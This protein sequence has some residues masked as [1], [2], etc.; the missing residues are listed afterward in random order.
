MAK[1]IKEDQEAIHPASKDGGR[2]LNSRNTE[3]E[4]M[5]EI[6]SL[7]DQATQ[8]S[9]DL[10]QQRLDQLPDSY[11]GLFDA[12]AVQELVG[13]RQ[14]EE[15][16]SHMGMT[17]PA[18]NNTQQTVLAIQRG[19]SDYRLRQ[20]QQQRAR[21]LEDQISLVQAV[22]EAQM[23]QQTA[24]LRRDAANRDTDLLADAYFQSA[25]QAVAQYIDDQYTA[26]LE[27]QEAL[28][29]AFNAQQ[30]EKIQQARNS[31]T[32]LQAIGQDTAYDPL[33]NTDPARRGTLN[34][35]YQAAY[36]RLHGQ[37]KN[38]EYSSGSIPQAVQYLNQ[39]VAGGIITNDES[40]TMMV[41][42]G[43]TGAKAKNI[44]ADSNGTLNELERAIRSRAEAFTPEGQAEQLENYL[45]I[46][47]KQGN[48]LFRDNNAHFLEDNTDW[49]TSQYVTDYQSRAASQR[50]AGELLKQR[51]RRYEDQMKPEDYDQL[52]RA[53]NGRMDELR[54][55]SQALSALQDRQYGTSSYIVDMGSGSQPGLQVLY[56]MTGKDVDDWFEKANTTLSKY[57][58]LVSTIATVEG[59]QG[60]YESN[61]L[62]DINQ[63]RNLAPS[64]LAFVNQNKAALGDQYTQ[65]RQQ[66]EDYIQVLN[67]IGA[68]T[69]QARDDW[70]NSEI[71]KLY[72]AGQQDPELLKRY[73]AMKQS[74]DAQA[75]LQIMEQKLQAQAERNRLGVGKDL[76]FDLPTVQEW[77]AAKQAA[78]PPALTSKEIQNKIDELEKQI[79]DKEQSRSFLDNI[80]DWLVETFLPNNTNGPSE[81]Q[82]VNALKDQLT[83]YKEQLYYAENDERLS[84][85]PQE[86]QQKI[87]DYTAR[88]AA[89][90]F[91]KPLGG[92][93]PSDLEGN[94]QF[95]LK[96]GKRYTAAEIEQMLSELKPTDYGDLIEEL[97]AAGFDGK[98]I[99]DYVQLRQGQDYVRLDN[100]ALRAAAENYPVMT[101]VASIL[102]APFKLGGIFDTATNALSNA[103]TGEERPL[104]L[105]QDAYL[106]SRIQSNVR[107]QISEDIHH[108]LGSFLYQT[109][110][111]MGDFLLTAPM[112]ALP[113]GQAAVSLILGGGAATDTA[114]DIAQRGGTASQAFWGG[115][116]AGAAEAAFEHFSIS[117]LLKPK[118]TGGVRTYIT[119]V[120]KGIGIEGSEETATEI[121]NLLADSFLMGDRSHFSLSKQAYMAKGLSSQ[122]AE[123]AALADLAGQVGLAFAGGA[124]S[125]GILHGV[126]SG[127]FFANSRMDNPALTPIDRLLSGALV[128]ETYG[129]L[130]TRPGSGMMALQGGDS[131]GEIQDFR[132]GFGGLDGSEIE[133]EPGR[134]DRRGYSENERTRE[135][136]R[137]AFTRRT[138]EATQAQTGGLGRLHHLDPY[139]DSLLSY[140]ETE[141]SDATAPGRA[142][143]QLQGWGIDAALAQ[144][145][146]ESNRNGMTTW[147]PDAVTTPDGRVIISSDSRLPQAELAEH[148]AVHVLER[149]RSPLFDEYY[150]ILQSEIIKHSKDY[151]YLATEIND[152]Y[153]RGNLDIYDVDSLKPIY[154]E[155]FAY[156]HQFIQSDPDWAAEQFSGAFGDWDGVVKASNQLAEALHQ[157][158]VGPAGTMD[159]SGGMSD[160]LGDS[161][162]DR[163]DPTLTPI[164][165]LLKGA[166]EA[167]A[168][169]D[170]L[171]GMENG[172][173]GT[174]LSIDADSLLSGALQIL[175]PDGSVGFRPDNDSGIINQN[176]P[177]TDILQKSTCTSEE[178][179]LYLKKA[180]GDD[181]AAQFRLTGQWPEN[182]Q[183][184][185]SSASLNP[186]GS[187]DWSKAPERGYHISKSGKVDRH[188]Y[189]PELD[190]TVD[191]YGSSNG[192]FVSPVYNGKP[193][194]YDQRSLPYIEDSS[195]YHQF[196]IIGDFS[197]LER[198]I[199]NCKDTN[200]SADIED[201]VL[202]WYNGR[203]DMLVTYAGEI[204]A[205]D[206]WGIGGGIQYEL[207][208]PIDWLEAL[209]LIEEIY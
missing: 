94:P 207:P 38:G 85:L 168:Q 22:G 147:H 89:A 191:R 195:Q 100:E 45:D 96:N 203:Y 153:Y 56:G 123:K 93:L 173:D 70:E 190:E 163:D 206:G 57:N 16:M 49:F 134:A 25:R 112:A 81:R 73:D 187:I 199:K 116:A 7:I 167:G 24:A 26:F 111:S 142:V 137:E 51:L 14:I 166:Q 18:L 205:V 109:G 92:R 131:F 140:M 178:L 102:A 75:K 182:I 149:L 165:R 184:P 161:W 132:G 41:A 19:N 36:D 130:Q 154:R 66:I 120:L 186:D 3:T 138:Q 97:D 201:Y 200:L 79:E 63:L 150:E 106:A 174:Q 157:Q 196:R 198:Y 114:V 136:T 176:V 127:L 20:A 135:E 197:Q 145:A 42:L 53:V 181:A 158:G 171:T 68:K 169:A 11:Q 59:W 35:Y 151:I 95:L 1:T 64:M 6:S 152:K 77:V 32:A 2:Q 170:S 193:F 159:S 204:A 76:D 115:L 104:D 139:G 121:T 144:G 21:E 65:A 74:L 124:L 8:A 15:A 128:P 43:I 83:T 160:V 5:E 72:I 78:Q 175:D 119:N 108:P 82:K 180:V 28:Q 179:S 29:S 113:G 67:I 90:E 129:P 126:Q 23:L 202:R 40:W 183:V 84:S 71:G 44:S 46:W 156:V 194:P 155:L 164:D 105:S 87:Q 117:A 13:R 188:V 118:N 60:L 110:M 30:N 125:G 88:S 47:Y 55:S 141:A 31:L 162:K 17:A 37:S 12:N 208:L 9:T 189:T 185:K 10:Y 122:E 148:E 52:V 107:G 143:L 69:Q 133:S 54:S 33:A 48:R 50:L 103:I 62:Q 172:M 192:R 58:Q 98:D 86:L 99:I 146:I 209:G 101:S 91:V 177:I 39:L 34:T 80:S 61:V 4:A 27:E